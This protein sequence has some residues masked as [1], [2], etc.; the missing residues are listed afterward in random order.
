MPGQRF[1]FARRAR[2]DGSRCLP[3]SL[4]VRRLT[5]L[6]VPSV[7]QWPSG[8]GVSSLA[9]RL[10]SLARGSTA[11]RLRGPVEERAAQVR[12]EPA[13]RRPMQYQRS[14]LRFR[15]PAAEPLRCCARSRWPA[16][17][18]P[19]ARWRFALTNDGVT[20]VQV[21]LLEWISIPYIAAGLVAWW[22]RPDSRL[23]LL[24]IVGGFATAS[25]GSRSPARA[26][27]HDR[28]GL[29]RPAG[30]H[31]P[32]RLP[33]VPRR[34]AEVAFR[35]RARRGRLRLGDRPPARQDVAR[36]RRPAEPAGALDAT[37]AA[38][39]VEQV[40]LLSISALCLIGIGVLAARRRHARPAA[41]PAGGA[42]D[43]LV[44]ARS[45][46]DRRPVR[47]AAPSRGRGFQTIQR[48]T[49]LVIG[50][51]P[52]AFLIGLLDA[53]LARSAVGDLFVELRAD[54]SP[55]ASPGRACP[56]TS[57]S[58][59]DARVLAARVRDLGRPRRPAASSC[60]NRRSAERRR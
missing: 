40:Q 5:P 8:S 2:G 22:R 59:A 50:I 21:A 6:S 9:R 32:A 30:G 31:L 17:S 57:R 18:S 53:R 3:P 24:M 42:A 26:S 55:A 38:H 11:V 25:P 20:G 16:C 23:G 48:A 7:A 46:D 10:L 60:P 35:A 15:T 13:W 47:V 56:R 4:R 28:R 58:V 54:P 34:A 43:R 45:G 39:T 37:G 14:R 41:A 33:R 19:A 29:R 1:E 52:F 49:L 51:S 27:A 44:R 36:R 12:S